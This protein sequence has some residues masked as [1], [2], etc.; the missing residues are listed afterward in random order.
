MMVP[1]QYI[2]SFSNSTEYT[3]SSAGFGICALATIGQEY[4]FNLP[5][6]CYLPK[7]MRQ[8]NIHDALELLKQVARGLGYYQLA[9]ANGVIMGSKASIMISKS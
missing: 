4:S 1:D 8:K 9:D 7:V 2:L 6:A 5:L 3:L